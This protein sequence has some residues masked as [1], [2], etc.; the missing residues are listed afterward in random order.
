[1]ST[2]YK[3]SKQFH[4]LLSDHFGCISRDGAQRAEGD[5][6]QRLWT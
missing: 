4:P 6:N 1:M 2:K 5:W 3:S